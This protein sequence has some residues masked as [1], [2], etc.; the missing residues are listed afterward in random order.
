[1]RTIMVTSRFTRTDLMT[2]VELLRECYGGKFG[3]QIHYPAWGRQ[4]GLAW[5]GVIEEPLLDDEFDGRYLCGGLKELVNPETNRWT[6]PRPEEGWNWHRADWEKNYSVPA[7]FWDEHRKPPEWI[8]LSEP[9]LAF[10]EG[11]VSLRDN[12]LYEACNTASAERLAAIS[13]D[14]RLAVLLAV[15]QNPNT[16]DAGLRTVLHSLTL[17]RKSSGRKTADFRPKV[18]RAVAQNPN[19]TAGTLLKVKQRYFLGFALQA[20]VERKLASI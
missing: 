7:V 3:V 10:P 2:D 19:A 12:L 11:V 17:E 8:Q 6:V 16:T 4:N 5:I 18:G 20:E 1:M 9:N 14:S 13:K 15:A